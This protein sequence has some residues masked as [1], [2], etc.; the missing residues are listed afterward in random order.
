MRYLPYRSEK[1]GRIQSCHMHSGFIHTVIT[2]A[3]AKLFFDVCHQ[4]I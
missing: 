2:K 1:S 4:L 3:K